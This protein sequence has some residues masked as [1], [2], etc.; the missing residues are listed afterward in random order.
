VIDSRRYYSSWDSL[1]KGVVIDIPEY[2][3]KEL[4]LHG[5]TE[6]VEFKEKIGRSEKI[7]ET[8]VAFANNRGGVILFGINDSSDVVGLPE[9]KHGETITNI[10]RRHCNPQIKYEIS[11]RQLEEKDII[12]VRVEEGRDKP[13][14]VRERGPYIRAHATNRIMTRQEMDEIYRQ[15]QS[16]YPGAY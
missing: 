15:K 11:K 12:L 3:I 9:G 14:F 2:G 4:I 8:A 7:A 13:Y 10:L 5:E 16:G 1:P 6:T